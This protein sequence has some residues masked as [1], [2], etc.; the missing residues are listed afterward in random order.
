MKIWLSKNSEVSVSDQL[1]EQVT[2]GVASQDLQIGE[3]L[4]ST[5][6]IARRFHIHQNTVIAAY[7]RLAEAGLVEFKKGSGVYVIRTKKYNG[8]PNGLEPIIDRFLSEAVNSGYTLTEIMDQLQHRIHAAK[9]TQFLLVEPDVEL[10][11]ILLEEIERA[12]GCSV[13]GVSFEDFAVLRKDHELQV[14]AF[15]QK[16]KVANACPSGRNCIFLWPNSVPASMSGRSRPSNSDLIAIISGWEKFLALAK[17]FLLAANI[18]S[19]TIITRSPDSPDWTNGLQAASLII[20]DSLTAKHFPDD[21]RV[22]IF[23]LI[24]DDSLAELRSRI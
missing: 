21:D 15:T 24:S 2:L 22:R 6:E 3:K 10:R 12:T 8:K 1:V 11:K 14:T 20:C 19:D 17:L 9:P 4:P 23:P 13:D 7:R 18:E 5:R 16:E